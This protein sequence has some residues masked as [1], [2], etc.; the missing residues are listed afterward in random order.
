MKEDVKP[1]T[2]AVREPQM[3]REKISRPN[4]SVPPQWSQ[5]GGARIE[6]KS[7]SSGLYGETHWQNT[8]ANII[9]QM[10]TKL[11]APSGCWRV[12]SNAML[13]RRGIVAEGRAAT[14]ISGTG[15]AGRTPHRAGRPPD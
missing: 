4:A 6:A 2:S 14:D 13:G 1:M 12:N 8:P 9:T 3:M 11:A 10:I 7:M 15:C 5:E